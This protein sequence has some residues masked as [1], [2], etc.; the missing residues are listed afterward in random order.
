MQHKF[1]LMQYKFHG[2]ALSS[3]I[4][5]V[6]ASGLTAPGGPRW[7]ENDHDGKLHLLARKWPR[8]SGDRAWLRSAGGHHRCRR[9]GQ[10]PKQD[11]SGHDAPLRP[12]W[13]SRRTDSG[14]RGGGG[15]AASRSRGAEIY[16]LPAVERLVYQMTALTSALTDKF[17]AV[18]CQGVR[19][20]QEGAVDVLCKTTSP[21][22]RSCPCGCVVRGGGGGDGHTS[23]CEVSTCPPVHLIRLTKCTDYLS[24]VDA[25]DVHFTVAHIPPFFAVPCQRQLPTITGLSN[26]S[27]FLFHFSKQ[28]LSREQ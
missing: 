9:D 13:R 25:R 10:P 23:G 17:P 26:F 27:Q 28:P 20:S 19:S 14:D 21:Q 8:R 3:S 16:E 18:S 2:S 22:P 24:P 6:L 15:G 11:G 7:P 5:V 12:K 1:N 4:M